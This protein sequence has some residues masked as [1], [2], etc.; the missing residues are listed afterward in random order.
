MWRCHRAA[1]PIFYGVPCAS[2]VQP[3]GSSQEFIVSHRRTR[4]IFSNQR[5]SGFRRVRVLSDKASHGGKHATI[6]RR[7]K[8]IPLSPS[9]RPRLLR[10]VQAGSSWTTQ[11]YEVSEV[12]AFF[13]DLQWK[14][15]MRVLWAPVNLITNGVFFFFSPTDILTFRK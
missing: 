8:H 6:V 13:R 2:H 12:H 3:P 4:Y 11:I 5:I 1:H 7:P 10:L 15:R 9:S 14:F